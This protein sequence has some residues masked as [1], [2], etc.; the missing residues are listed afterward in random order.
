VPIEEEEEELATSSA[1]NIF[2]PLT[3]H[4]N[5]QKSTLIIH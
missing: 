4:L 5:A 3:M 1:R 2:S